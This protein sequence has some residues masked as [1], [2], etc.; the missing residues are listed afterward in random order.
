MFVRL[1]SSFILMSFTTASLASQTQDYNTF[2]DVSL[3]EKKE[4]PPPTSLFNW[5]FCCCIACCESE[6]ESGTQESY[7]TIVG[8]KDNEDF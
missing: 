2:Y 3:S 8:K 1:Y 6:E 5:L 7:I 4:S